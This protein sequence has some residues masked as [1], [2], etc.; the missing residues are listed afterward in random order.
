MINVETV[1][2]GRIF[3]PW[4]LDEVLHKGVFRHCEGLS[5]DDVISFRE[6]RECELNEI[7]AS[8]FVNLINAEKIDDDCVSGCIRDFRKLSVLNV[9]D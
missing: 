6:K 8:R 7:Q 5:D 9:A 3:M 4:H 2:E 1:L